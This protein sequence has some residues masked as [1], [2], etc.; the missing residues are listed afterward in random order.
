M[1]LNQNDEGAEKAET[2]NQYFRYIKLRVSKEIRVAS[3]Y[4]INLELAKAK[5]IAHEI[6]PISWTAYSLRTLVHYILSYLKVIF[7]ETAC[8]FNESRQID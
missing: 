8:C 6:R 7:Y 2:G 4:G 3:D 1:N 5:N